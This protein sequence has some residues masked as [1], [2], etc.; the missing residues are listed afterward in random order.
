MQVHVNPFIYDENSVLYSAE[1]VVM[2][3]SFW[4]F[5]SGLQR[6]LTNSWSRLKQLKSFSDVVLI[7]FDHYSELYV[8]ELKAQAVLA[9]KVDMDQFIGVPA[10]SYRT[11]HCAKVNVKKRRFV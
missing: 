11:I 1:S 2:A 9:T 5:V 4:L 10:L 7:T 8:I 3:N 6:L